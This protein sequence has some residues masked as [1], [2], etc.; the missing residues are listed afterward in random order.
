MHNVQIPMFFEQWYR[1]GFRGCKRTPKSFD[2]AKNRERCLKIR[3]K[4]LKTFTTPWKYEQKWRPT[5]FDLKK[6]APR[7]Q[8]SLWEFRQK[9]FAP[10]YTYVF[11]SEDG[12]YIKLTSIKKILK[13]LS[14]VRES[15]Q[16]IAF[17]QL[18][19][20][21]IVISFVLIFK[22]TYSS[23][24]MTASNSKKFCK[25]HLLRKTSSLNNFVQ[26]LLWQTEFSP[27]LL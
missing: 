12:R 1:T 24:K 5:S 4:S 23:S 14:N 7:F 18:T 25:I 19:K 2:L 20:N 16:L 27:L 3:V 8:A 9:S 22:T 6:M 13:K 21:K 10:S 17:L 26:L 11:E 15:W